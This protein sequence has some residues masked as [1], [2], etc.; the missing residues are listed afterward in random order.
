[1]PRSAELPWPAPLCESVQESVHQQFIAEK[2]LKEEQ[3]CLGV[4][5]CVCVHD[6]TIA[7]YHVIPHHLYCS[8]YSAELKLAL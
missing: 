5:V 2:S 8:M 1:M 3:V 6:F 7:V 4:C